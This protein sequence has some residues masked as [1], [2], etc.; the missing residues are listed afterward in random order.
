VTVAA[1]QGF[2]PI[3]SPTSGHPPP[4]GR[5]R[6]KVHGRGSSRSR[7]GEHNLFRS[8]TRGLTGRPPHYEDDRRLAALAAE[9][10]VLQHGQPPPAARSPPSSPCEAPASDQGALHR[11]GEAAKSPLPPSLA[12]PRAF[13]AAASDGGEV[14]RAGEGGLRRVRVRSPPVSPKSGAMRGPV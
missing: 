13:S 4:T 8:G 3:R 9:A 11:G 6:A 5:W 7:T 2:S 12:S 1:G 14:R 10:H